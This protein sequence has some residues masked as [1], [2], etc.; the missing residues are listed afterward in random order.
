MRAPRNAPAISAAQCD[1]RDEK[2][3]DVKTLPHILLWRARL[4]ARQRWKNPGRDKV[5][6]CG[7]KCRRRRFAACDAASAALLGAQL[8]AWLVAVCELD[9]R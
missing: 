7:K 1:Q 9:A 3:G 6:R 5:Q 2:I 4:R 8:H